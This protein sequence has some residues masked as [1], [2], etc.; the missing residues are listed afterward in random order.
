VVTGNAGAGGY[1]KG[2]II[3]K[4]GQTI[5]IYVGSQ[6]PNGITSDT[7]T[8]NGGGR[9]TYENR[10]AARGGIGGGATDFRLKN[11]DWDNA[12]SLNSRIMVAGGGG[13]GGSDDYISTSH[14][15]RANG[16]YGGGLTVG[17]GISTNTNIKNATGGTQTSGGTF[18]DYNCATQYVVAAMFGKGGAYHWFGGGGGGGGYYGGGVGTVLCGNGHVIG[19]GGSSSFISGMAGCVA[20]DPTNQSEPRTQDTGS[21]TT[22]LNYSSTFGSNPTTWSDGQ[23][24]LFTNPSMIDGE[25]F[26]WNTGTGSRGNQTPMPTYSNPG[27]FMTGN[28]DHGHARITFIN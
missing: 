15:I 5:Y 8:F 13:G 2:D 6:T 19:G 28:T 3:L 4:A 22:A 23:E 7:H 20:I 9:L 16:G 26:E 21:N 14:P 17:E 12:T 24:I 1:C 10:P 11:G 25:G 18:T 27:T